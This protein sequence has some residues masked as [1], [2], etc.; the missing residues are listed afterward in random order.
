[1][2]A[3]PFSVTISIG[4]IYAILEK[5]N[6]SPRTQPLKPANTRLLQKF[7]GNF[8]FKSEIG[9]ATCLLNHCG[10]AKGLRCRNSAKSLTTRA[11]IPLNTSSFASLLSSYFVNGT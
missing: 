6:R 10:I 11:A 5:K 3:T 9:E 2:Q 8:E 7:R 1:M 4:K